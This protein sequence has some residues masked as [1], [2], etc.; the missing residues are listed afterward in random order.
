MAVVRALIESNANPNVPDRQGR[1]P[2]VLAA[3]W[4][5]SQV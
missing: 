3:F 4:Y 2:V 1:H 5:V